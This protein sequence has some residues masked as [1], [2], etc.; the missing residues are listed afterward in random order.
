[1]SLDPITTTNIPNTLSFSHSSRNTLAVLNNRHSFNT[2]ITVT[3]DSSSV[4]V[5][6]SPLEPR[7]RHFSLEAQRVE[8]VGHWLL[9]TEQF[10]AWHSLDGPCERQNATLFCYGN[11]GVGKTFIW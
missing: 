3:D 6:L 11:P 4:L 9:R 5:W 10:R 8:G 7:I 1:M 2:Q